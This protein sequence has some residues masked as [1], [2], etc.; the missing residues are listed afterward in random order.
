[1]FDR[2]AMVRKQAVRR[3]VRLLPVMF[4]MAC[5]GDDGG[6]G[7]AQNRPP[8]IDLGRQIVLSS[9]TVFKPGD[10][11]EFDLRALD[12]DV[13]PVTY[14]WSL[15]PTIGTGTFSDPAVRDPAW[16]VG[17]SRGSITVTCVAS[18]G[19]LTDTWS[20][21]FEVGAEIAQTQ[22]DGAVTWTQ[23]GGPYVITGDVTV[24]PT[25]TL[26]VE[27]GTALYS[28]PS[29]RIL[30]GAVVFER[31]TI[32]VLGT[33]NFGAPSGAVTLLSGGLLPSAIPDAHRGIVFSGDASGTI[34]RARIERGVVAVEHRSTGLVVVAHG[35]SLRDNSENGVLVSAV[36][37]G[38]FEMRDSDVQDN[39][40]GLTLVSG[41]AEIE[42]VD[43]D[44]HG[45]ALAVSSDLVATDCDF[46]ASESA[47]LDVRKLV[48][49]PAAFTVSVTGSNFYLS[50][51]PAVKIEANTCAFASLDLRGN[52]WG[53]SFTAD[54]VLDRFAGRD[55]CNA[56]V[57]TWTD[58]ECS[59]GSC[60]WSTEAFDR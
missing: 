43:F 49:N 29:Q 52:F 28:R 50:G 1:M 25:G 55:D 37:S 12:P 41:V 38:R 32:R 53:G 36:G 4:L 59:D 20:R 7:P 15:S 13:Q 39:A 44:G 31:N 6:T 24:G 56:G 51:A 33:L 27:A 30:G 3:A 23:A 46:R 45:F 11:V 58:F 16:T 47:H 48:A 35:S 17:T 57:S 60:D 14:T 34:S 9:V 42:R 2:C 18:D 21:T 26:T 5:G 22:I 40:L 8:E 54:Q 19:A 10:V